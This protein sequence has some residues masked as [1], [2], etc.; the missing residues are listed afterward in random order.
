MRRFRPATAGPPPT[1]TGTDA[2]VLL[3]YREMDACRGVD[4]S[5]WPTLC[6]AAGLR[7]ACNPAAV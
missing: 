3:Q 1:G 2:V 5:D 4:V 7:A 6:R